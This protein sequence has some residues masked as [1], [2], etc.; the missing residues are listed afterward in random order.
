MQPAPGDRRRPEGPS[1]AQ[2]GCS[3][4][5][6]QNPSEAEEKADLGAG[7][8]FPTSH[9]PGPGVGR[10]LGLLLRRR[11]Q[12]LSSREA[13]Q[14]SNFPARFSEQQPLAA[15][16][17]V[18]LR[19]ISPCKQS[20]APAATWLFSFHDLLTSSK[21][22]SA[23]PRQEIPGTC[24][25]PPGWNALETSIREREA[26][27]P[28]GERSQSHI[29]H[30]PPPDSLSSQPAAQ[31]L[32]QLCSHRQNLHR[33]LSHWSLGDQSPL[34]WGTEPRHSLAG[35][36]EVVGFRD[37]S[38]GSVMDGTGP[39]PRRKQSRPAVLPKTSEPPTLPTAPHT[40]FLPTPPLSL[41]LLRLK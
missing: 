18:G 19:A 33:K 27:Q 26:T 14:R 2:S 39:A 10:G 12:F 40:T 36:G 21:G 28:A 34:G 17:P 15:E 20:P 41:L 3:G 8:Q 4:P 11:T 24:Q 29:P 37:R 32:G 16:R 30:G 9:C 7:W 25:V 5:C 22:I 38:W 1:G 31:G 23:W 35:Q 6:F 13:E